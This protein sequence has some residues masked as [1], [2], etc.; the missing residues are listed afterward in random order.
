MTAPLQTPPHAIH[1]RSLI[2]AMSMCTLTKPIPLLCNHIMR[3]LPS[4]DSDVTVIFKAQPG[5][6]R[7]QHIA[8]GLHPGEHPLPGGEAPRG[9]LL[10]P[11]S[12]HQTERNYTVILGSHRNTCLKF[13]KDGQLCEQVRDK[14]KPRAGEDRWGGHVGGGDWSGGRSIH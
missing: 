5:S 3:P 1:A 8:S 10:N 7:W 4:G 6:R 12:Q 11:V 2:H 9:Q 13:E 14:S